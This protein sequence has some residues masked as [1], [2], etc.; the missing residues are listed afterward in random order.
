LAGILPFLLIIL[1]FWFLILRP[2]RRRQQ[3]LAATQKGVTVGTEVMLTSG[4]FGRVASLDDQTINVEIAPG[5]TVRVVRQAVARVVDEP[6]GTVTDH[7]D[8]LPGTTDGAGEGPGG[9]ETDDPR[10]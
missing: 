9:T 8:Q 3:E 10:L 4:I 1:V 7:P 6:A 2:Q 5:T